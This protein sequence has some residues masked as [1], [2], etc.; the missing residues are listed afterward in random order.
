[1]SFNG[2]GYFAELFLK[3]R[4]YTLYQEGKQRSQAFDERLLSV[5]KGR[6]IL[7]LVPNV[8]YWHW[9][10]KP[11]QFPDCLTPE[12]RER[13]RQISPITT[14]RLRELVGVRRNQLA[15]LNNGH[16]TQ[17]LEEWA[18]NGAIHR[19]VYGYPLLDRRILDFCLS[20]PAS[21]FFKKGWKRYLY[22]NAMT[23]ILPTRVQWKKF[24]HEPA[25]EAR[26]KANVKNNLAQ[27]LESA[28][29]EGN[30]IDFSCVRQQL[31]SQK[32]D[33]FRQKAQIGK[34]LALEIICTK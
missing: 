30:C 14:H 34:L 25:V 31:S 32:D 13:M 3:G 28:E 16:I 17:R 22:R 18:I 12:F 20:I 9:R 23:G 8:I 21:Q 19:I 24:K 29:N 15:L 5:L 26:H 10:E 33:D 2:R 27:W 6:T 4:W 11:L 7:P 1:M